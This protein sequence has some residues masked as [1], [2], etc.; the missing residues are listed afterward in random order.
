LVLETELVTAFCR[1][2][3]TLGRRSFH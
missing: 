2:S 1:L 3:N